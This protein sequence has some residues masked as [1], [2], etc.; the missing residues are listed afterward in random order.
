MNH[1]VELRLTG[2]FDSTHV[3]AGTLAVTYTASSE[4]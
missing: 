2:D 1:G 4:A 3:D